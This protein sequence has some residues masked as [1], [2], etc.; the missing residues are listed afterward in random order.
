VSDLTR[1]HTAA[2]GLL[3]IIDDLFTA[4]RQGEG[5][6]DLALVQHLLRTP[7]NQIIG[8]S[9]LLQEDVGEHGRVDWVA[10]LQRI[11]AAARHLLELIDDHLSGAA[12][13]GA[14]KGNRFAPGSTGPRII[15]ASAKEA[16]RA[17]RPEQ[18]SVLVVDDNA[19][20]CDMLSRRLG[21]DGHEVS[22]AETGRQA[23][24]LLRKEPVDLVLLDILK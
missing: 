18:G 5:T 20:N 17:H 8:Y 1:I 19:L 11:N 12:G 15:T 21:R 9:E 14:G 23:L 7:L 6:A 10:D 16:R 3:D 2:K 24:D 22:V 4:E 13:G